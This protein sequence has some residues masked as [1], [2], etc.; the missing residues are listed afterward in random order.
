MGEQVFAVHQPFEHH[1]AV[2]EVH[3]VIHGAPAI[4]A[5]AE[6]QGVGNPEAGFY[7]QVAGLMG[8]NVD[9]V[10]DLRFLHAETVVGVLHRGAH[11]HAA[12]AYFKVQPVDFKAGTGGG[13][14][15][16]LEVSFRVLVVGVPSV[17]HH[18]ERFAKA[19][20]VN[21]FA[22]REGECGIGRGDGR[23]GGGGEGPGKDNGLL[24]LD[25]QGDK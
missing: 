18:A 1:I 4:D 7:G 17:G 21:A 15:G 13:S 24:C 3:Q 9:G 19:Q 2:V 12:Q 20:G 10:S 22:G 11:I 5:D 16:V 14:K 8:G 23:F 25:I 6:G